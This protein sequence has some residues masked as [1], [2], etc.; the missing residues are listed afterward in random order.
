VS[1]LDK[2]IEA[3][4]DVVIATGNVVGDAVE[5]AIN[6]TGA[7]VVTALTVVVEIGPSM[8]IAST[9]ID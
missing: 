9:L 2:T 4:N 7:I 6:I 5:A 3:T 8:L 1:I